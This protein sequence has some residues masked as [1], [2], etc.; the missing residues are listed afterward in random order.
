M[1][2]LQI[3]QERL[4]LARRRHGM[5][6][7]LLAEKT[8][9]FKTDISKYERGVS[10]PALPRFVRLA[11]ALGISTD[12]LLGRSEGR[13]LTPEEG[14]DM[15]HHLGQEIVPTR[16]RS[17]RTPVNLQ[18]LAHLQACYA[19]LC[20]Q[21]H[22]R[23]PW[24]QDDALTLGRFFIL[25]WGHPPSTWELKAEGF[26]PYPATIR[27]LFGSVAAFHA[28]LPMPT[29]CGCTEEGRCESAHALYAR[30]QHGER[31]AGLLKAYRDHL[32]KKG[33]QPG[34]AVWGVEHGK[35]AGPVVTGCVE[36]LPAKEKTREE[37]PSA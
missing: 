20:A 23:S 37:H 7:D 16:S 4:L 2:R 33:I 24:R 21:I 1:E 22:P 30:W 35:D 13:A 36:L 17:S 14:G 11:D 10:L 31:Q 32:H 25:A 12:Y 26:L 5:T 27:R 19:T 28:A 15:S 3:F 34:K 6:Q 8:R 29:P 18:A 9:L